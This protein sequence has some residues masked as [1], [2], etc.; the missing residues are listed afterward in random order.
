MTDSSTR[1]RPNILVTG[2]PCVG[3]TA[4]ASLIAER[5]N[6]Y[7]VNVGDIISKHKFHLEY[8][9]S[10]Q[11][12]VLDE[13][14]LLDHLE[15]KFDASPD[16]EDD[17]SDSDDNEQQIQPKAGKKGNLVADY[18]S[19]DLFPERWFDLI[20]VLR[21]DTHILYDRLMKRGYSENKRSQNIQCEIM[22]VVLDE[23][24]ESYAKEIV[25]ELKS[26]GI[27]DME[28]NVDRI[29]AW[30]HQWIQDHQNNNHNAS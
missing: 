22:Q 28:Q 10:L 5:L 17:D 8:D 11:T 27:Q 21:A 23:A 30:Y 1:I 16:D 6:M 9:E 24:K 26:N 13:D 19:C 15:T 7:H 25:V 18:H 2:T 29:V 20:I 14:K 4:T 3:K 12:H